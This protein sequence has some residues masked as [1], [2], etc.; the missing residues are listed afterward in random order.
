MSAALTQA[1]LAHVDVLA[2]IHASAF[3]PRE[4]WGRDAIGLQLALPGVFGLLDPRG[5]MI[6]T[7]VAADE[8]EVLTLAVDPVHRR[9]GI[10]ACLLR[11]AMDAARE[12]GGRSMALEVSVDNA[13]ARKLYARA[14][15]TEIGRR[16]RYYADGSDALIMRATL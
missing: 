1:T 9:H 7:R 16:V 13:A 12:R 11:A 4:V 5:G 15:F 6:M 14:G 2:A 8:A 3:P 10:G